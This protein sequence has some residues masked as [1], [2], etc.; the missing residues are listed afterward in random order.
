[1]AYE[2]DSDKDLPGAP[3]KTPIMSGKGTT[4]KKPI[5]MLAAMKRRTSKC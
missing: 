1:M 5:N 4:P 3:G 2:K